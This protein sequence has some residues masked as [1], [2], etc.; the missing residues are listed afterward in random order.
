MI[1]T[2][3]ADIIATVPKLVTSKDR[4]VTSQ[5]I[6]MSLL[7]LPN[8]LLC[9][10]SEHLGTEKDISLFAQV[11]KQLYDLTTTHLYRIN[12][13]HSKSSALL[14]AATHGRTSTAKKALKERL[15]V[16]KPVAMTS[17]AYAQ[18]TPSIEAAL[19]LAA[20][21]N[22][23]VMVKF[24]IGN[25]ARPHWGDRNR[26]RNAME[27]ASEQGHTQ[28]VKLLLDLGANPRAG[29]GLK[30]FSIQV[31]AMRG[32]IEIVQLLVDA[33]E[34]PD[35]C[36][37][38]PAGGSYSPLQAA[39]LM[40]NEP[41]AKLLLSK[42]AKVNHRSAIGYTPLE[43]AVRKRRLPLVRILL[44]AGAKVYGGTSNRRRRLQTRLTVLE[45]AAQPG[46]EEY[47]ELLKNE[48]VHPWSEG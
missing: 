11:N 35:R 37:G 48:T 45:C 30:A 6:Q 23:E 10:I 3:A 38:R 40:A 46:Y 17:S 15:D 4:C 12:A 20:E 34:D 16:E 22:Q 1:N 19:V 24:L 9:Q 29:F 21:N 2:Y 31:A 25:G 18:S 13:K 5:D 43:L 41:M 36:N 7:D 32:H 26:K 39:V 44:D 42:G 33:G 28:I 47:L 8:E 27:V 14:W